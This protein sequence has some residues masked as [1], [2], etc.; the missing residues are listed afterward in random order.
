[1]GVII[2]GICCGYEEIRSLS[3]TCPCHRK[4]L[5][6]EDKLTTYYKRMQKFYTESALRKPCSAKGLVADLFAI[7][8]PFQM[9]ER[10]YKSY[11]TMVITDIADVNHQDRDELM[12]NWDEGVSAGLVHAQTRLTDWSVVPLKNCSLA[13]RI[14]PIGRMHTSMARKQ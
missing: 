11:A 10:S 12:A 4:M 9:L 14:E 8:V 7:G 13:H 5:E 2:L 6:L 3:R 1:M